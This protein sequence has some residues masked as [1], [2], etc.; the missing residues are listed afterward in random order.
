LIE[1]TDRGI[2][3]SFSTNKLIKEWIEVKTNE[4]QDNNPGLLSL[5]DANILGNYEV[6]YVGV[7][8]A[9]DGNPAGGGFRG[10]NA[11]KLFLTD[12]IYQHI[13]NEPVTNQIMVINY[14][15]GILFGVFRL[16]VVLEG[17]AQKLVESERLKIKERYGNVMSLGSVQANFKSPLIGIEMQTKNNTKN[18]IYTI[19]IGP[20][21]SV[22]LDT[23]YVCP[24]VR[25]GKGSRGSTF[26]FRRT[27]SSASDG[28]IRVIKNKVIQGKKLGTLM[29]IIG[30]SILWQTF[31]RNKINATTNLIFKF[32]KIMIFGIG[33][34]FNILFGIFFL[35]S[36]GGIID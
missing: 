2:N 22:V 3:A 10:N 6:A 35:F 13:L 23:P 36:K 27:N 5:E 17:V 29:L 33:G 24:L 8:N 12:G 21:S 26:I 19:R 31:I 4:Y 18:K 11:R 14:I 9:Q 30:T 34:I 16:S 28:Y 32:L 25:L 20:P 7:G 1:D 15:T